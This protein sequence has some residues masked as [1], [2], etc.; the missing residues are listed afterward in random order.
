MCRLR[1]GIGVVLVV[2][3]VISVELLMVISS[4]LH[5]A[6]VA[7]ATEGIIEIVAFQTHPILRYVVYG[8]FL[9]GL[10]RIWPFLHL[11]HCSIL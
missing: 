3:I 4:A 1:I 10:L 6:S 5:F 2:V 11:C 8:F 9:S 7:F